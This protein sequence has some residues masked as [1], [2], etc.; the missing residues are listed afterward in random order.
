[1]SLTALYFHLPLQPLARQHPDVE[2]TPSTTQ[3]FP[4]REAELDAWYVQPHVQ[5]KT[6]L[7]LYE[8][9]FAHFDQL[10]TNE[11]RH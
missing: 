11:K 8:Q 10:W 1:M 6:P 7:D 5:A 2:S 4:R 9:A 3:A